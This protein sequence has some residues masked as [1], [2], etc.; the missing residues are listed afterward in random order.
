MYPIGTVMEFL[1]VPGLIKPFEWQDP[2]SGVT[3]KLSTSKLY[4]VLSIE[5][6]S[7]YFIRET[8][9]FDGDEV[10]LERPDGSGGEAVEE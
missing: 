10:C 7:L 5:N 3:V 9:S 2:Q 6:W 8:G 1:H 4:T